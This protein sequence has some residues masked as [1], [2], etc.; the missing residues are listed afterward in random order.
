MS[1]AK[2]GRKGWIALALAV[3]A[4]LAGS[5]YLRLGRLDGTAIPNVRLVERLASDRS[6]PALGPRDADVV[7]TV[8]TDYQCPACRRAHPAMMA[9][10][11][12]DGRVRIVFRDLP[13]FGPVSQDAARIALAAQAQGLYPALHDAF[14]REP[15][16]LTPTVMKSLVLREGGD[17]QRILAAVEAGG[18][19]AQLANNQRDAMLLGIRGTPTYVVGRYRYMGAMTQTQ[20]AKAIARARNEGPSLRVGNP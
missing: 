13:V 11:R 12:E 14:M 6:A 16:K 8:F 15:R 19:G 7:L 1:A 20:F 4:G 2:P 17:W 10:A 3:L 9:T 5:L 18:P